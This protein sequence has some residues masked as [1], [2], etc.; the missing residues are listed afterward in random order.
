MGSASVPSSETP[1]ANRKRLASYV[2]GKD[3]L[4][5]QADAP[6]ILSQLIEGVA[7]DELRRRPAPAKWSVV[8]IIAHLADDELATTWRYHQMIEHNGEKLWS[9]DQDYWAKL[10]SY[11]SRDTKEALDL[12]R[13]LRQ[14]NLRMLAR[15]SRE[16]W[17]RQGLHTERGR[18]TVRDLASHMAAHDINHIEQIRRILHKD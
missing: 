3:P 16:E 12:F 7:D 14:A 11:A 2:A 9:F 5:M 4:E 15:L 6:G 18:M 8:E 17:D 10:G 13:L 1:E